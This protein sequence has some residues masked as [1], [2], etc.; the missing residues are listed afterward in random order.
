VSALN[1]YNSAV[2]LSCAAGTN[3]PPGTCTPSPGSLIPGNK[4]PFTV[5]VGGTP[6]D[7]NFNLRGAGADTNHVIHTAPVSL[8][9]V[10]Y[11]MSLPSPSSVTV[12]RGMTSQPVSFQITAAGSFNQSVNI[13]CASDIAD[14]ICTLNPGNT[15][16]PTS[17]AAVN[18]TATIDVPLGT[19]P[20]SY[21]VNLQASTAGA[22]STLSMS[23]EVD[24]VSSADFALNAPSSFPNVKVGSTGT[25]G[26]IS[27]TSQDGFS[28]MVTLSCPA[29]YGAG[30]CSI[31]PA[32]ISSF[33][34]TAKLT[35]NGTSFTAGSYS[36][37]IT[38]TSGSIA[39]SVPVAFDVGDYSISGTQTLSIVPGGQAQGT[40]KLSSNYSYAGNISATRDASVLAG[41]ICSLSA[42]SA[43][44][45]AGGGTQSFTANVS[46]PNSTSSGTFKLKINTQDSDG[47]PRHSQT[48]SLT[49]AQDFVVISSTPSQTVIA[50]QTSGPYALS[51]QPVG[52]SF[53]G[54]VT[55]A[56][57]GGLPAGA[58]CA[59]S[60]S[61]PV[62][63]GSSAVDVV[64]SISTRKAAKRES[65]FGTA[66]T[67]GTMLLPALVM[68]G[69][70][71]QKRAKCRLLI[72]FFAIPLL[73]IL[74]SCGGVSSGSGD[75]GGGSGNP[76]T[77]QV[78]VT[79]TS[80][81]TPS[82]PGQ[83]TV[84]TLVVD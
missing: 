51:V 18:M 3:G 57:T 23:F 78:T 54:A 26:V 8:R 60:P 55:L 25:T 16:Y 49:V 67:F 63:P 37:S 41:A 66:L 83:S 38:G 11:G 29:T 75:G 79:G 1:G 68:G 65:Q 27:I 81:G 42:T 53:A 70:A 61:T 10:D 64:M 72:I 12:A 24:V 58:Q 22:P 62:T 15:V 14:A 73:V 69:A 82:D 44:A 45:L 19:P 31:T 47:A 50:G 7:Y 59:F 77:Y 30:S 46:I 5:K 6:G 40:F 74:A 52:S 32:T 28:G 2:T 84:V 71:S 4:T 56:C 80:P 33:P 36:I 43:M 21:T 20:G 76:V 48:V 9:I 13:S 39:H 17:A 34:A 35:I